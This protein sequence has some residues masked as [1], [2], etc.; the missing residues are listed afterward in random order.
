MSTLKTVLAATV[1]LLSLIFFAYYAEP[2][3][4]LVVVEE[5]RP[6]P[7][8][9]PAV[10]RALLCEFT[11]C[12]YVEKRLEALYLR[13]KVAVTYE[14]LPAYAILIIAVLAT[15][16]AAYFASRIEGMRTKQAIA[17][18]AAV[19]GAAM[20]VLMLMRKDFKAA[21]PILAPV[22]AALLISA[23][24]LLWLLRAAGHEIKIR[25]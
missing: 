10:S 4:E 21:A 5:W 14:P 6:V 15:A 8:D 3:S 11:E 23:F 7:E 16:F 12:R 2:K 1:V 13:Y 22:A 20:T 9:M 24:I 25:K 19:Y 18:F 17:A